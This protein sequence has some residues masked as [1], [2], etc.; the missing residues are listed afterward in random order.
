MSTKRKSP[1]LNRY[2]R[3][4]LNREGGA[5]RRAI[6]PETNAPAREFE[7]ATAIPH[8]RQGGRASALER[9]GDVSAALA[10]LRRRE[11]ALRAERDDLVDELRKAGESWTLL[12]LRTGLSRQALLLRQRN[13][14]GRR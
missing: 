11:D 7:E 10:Q 8:T 13:V 5:Q 4:R 14:A 9:L 12:A 6:E 1:K 3:Q 2:Q